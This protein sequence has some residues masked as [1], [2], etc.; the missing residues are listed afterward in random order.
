MSIHQ[1]S[2]SF[3]QNIQNNECCK[4]NKKHKVNDTKFNE[5]CQKEQE[6]MSKSKRKR[7]ENVDNNEEEMGERERE[8]EGQSDE[9][10][11][12]GERVE[13]EGQEEGGG[14][15]F[16]TVDEL[17]QMTPWSYQ[18]GRSLGQ[19][20]G[21]LASRSAIQTS[22]YDR[23]INATAFFHSCISL[24]EYSS[25]PTVLYCT[26]LY[27]TVLYCTVL[28]CTVLYYTVLYCLLHK[29]EHVP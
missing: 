14:E 11:E 25:I 13:E 18:V 3:I 15:E 29:I 19:S 22:C 7:K 16:I 4:L 6:R 5:K 17:R 24:D 20:L 28:Y 12:D 26:V 10:K 8:R 27:C 1:S 21:H 9:E 2:A 23:I